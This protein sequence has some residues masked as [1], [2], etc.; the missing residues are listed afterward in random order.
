MPVSA[1]ATEACRHTPAAKLEEILLTCLFVIKPREL[2]TAAGQVPCGLKFPQAS[3]RRVEAAFAEL[4]VP[5]EALQRLI[6]DRPCDTGVGD[7]QIL[8]VQEQ[9]KLRS[10]ESAIAEDRT[11]GVAGEFHSG[12]VP[13]KFGHQHALYTA[14]GLKLESQRRSELIGSQA[15]RLGQDRSG[16]QAVLQCVAGRA[17]RG[18]PL[19]RPESGGRRSGFGSIPLLAVR[20]QYV[21]RRRRGPAGTLRFHCSPPC[22]PCQPFIMIKLLSLTQ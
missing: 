14:D 17:G 18:W 5:P 3:Q 20:I 4:P 7:A 9:F 22:E 21:C 15:K 19:F 2:S 12:G 11:F 1:A 8:P 13:G 16:S 6:C 10:L